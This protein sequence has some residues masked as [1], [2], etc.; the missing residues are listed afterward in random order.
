MIMK[1]KIFFEKEGIESI[2]DK[3]NDEYDAISKIYDEIEN[4]S[5]KINGEGNWQ[6]KGQKSFYNSYL[7]ISK[8]ITNNKLKIQNC[9]D[10]L[11]ETKKAYIDK[12]NQLLKNLEDNK[13]NLTI[14]S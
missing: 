14:N 13:D 4:R 12:D 6:G 7:S 3:L 8:K 1:N 5:K 11:R 2:L 10:F 9:N